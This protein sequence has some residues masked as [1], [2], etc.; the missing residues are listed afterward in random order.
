MYILS[1]SNFPKIYSQQ[2]GHY[3]L[4]QQIITDQ[5][6]IIVCMK[7]KLINYTTGWSILGYTYSNITAFGPYGGRGSSINKNRFYLVMALLGKRGSKLLTL[8]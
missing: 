3:R 1:I 5:L 4:Q 6:N 7:G 2:Y 8:Q